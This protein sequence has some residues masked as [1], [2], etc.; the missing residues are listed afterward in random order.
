MNQWL[1]RHRMQFLGW[2]VRV[3]HLTMVSDGSLSPYDRF[4]KSE[5]VAMRS[6]SSCER[7]RGTIP[8]RNEEMYLCKPTLLVRM[9]QRT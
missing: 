8:C 5:D 1:L 9:N 4:R 2:V 6:L 3:S 7:T